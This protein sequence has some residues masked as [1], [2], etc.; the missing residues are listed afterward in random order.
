MFWD[1][2]EILDK[3]G[4]NDET[5]S[6]EISDRN[7]E[8]SDIPEEGLSD[9]DL[10]LTQKDLVRQDANDALFGNDIIE[11]SSSIDNEET[12][13]SELTLDQILMKDS[14]NKGEPF[15]LDEIIPEQELSPDNLLALAWEKSILESSSSSVNLDSFLS[16]SPSFGG[17]ALKDLDQLEIDNLLGFG[18]SEPDVKNLTGIDTILNKRLIYYERLPM[19]E[20]VFDRLL[21]LLSTS[22]RNFTSDNVE[23]SLESMK[24]MRFGDYLNSIPLPAM[25]GVFRAEEWDNGG[26]LVVDSSLIY[27]IVDVLLGGKRSIT[28]SR[29]EGRPYTTIERNLIEKLMKVFLEELKNAFEPVSDVNFR[30][31]RM[32]INPHF[33]MISRS[34]NAGILVRLHV[35]IDDRGGRISLMLPYATIE[36][37]RE[38]LLQNFMGEKFG[39][40]SIWEQHLASQLWDTDVEFNVRL[41]TTTLSLGEVLNWKAGDYVGF[42]V[43]PASL[44]SAVSGDHE[45]F[46][47]NVGQK[48]GH[49]A[50]QIQENILQ[51]K[52]DTAS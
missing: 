15:T 12:E 39:R 25:I 41:G 19:M 8:A 27:S 50:L 37:I 3:D 10:L 31:E 2:E 13:S 7:E 33:A 51:K 42:P 48:N 46:K 35:E 6:S 4:L 52:M 45:L 43:T 23:I 29:L 16:D 20:V 28:A 5:S 30:F 40:D 32:E 18:S 24:T 1:N 21:R 17:N 44:V 14:E 26:I 38:L 22:L 34:T 9:E 36:P 47:G 49:V 11:Q